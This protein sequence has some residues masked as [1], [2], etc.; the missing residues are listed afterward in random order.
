MI[1]SKELLCSAVWNICGYGMVQN[2]ESAAAGMMMVCVFWK[3][4]IK[5]QTQ[6]DALRITR[7]KKLQ[8]T[9]ELGNKTFTEGSHDG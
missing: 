2:E 5:T 9:I 1:G 4:V 8:D 6:R 3:N 7:W